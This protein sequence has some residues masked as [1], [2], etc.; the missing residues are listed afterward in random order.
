MRTSKSTITFLTISINPLGLSW[1]NFASVHL[2]KFV[3]ELIITDIFHMAGHTYIIYADRY[4]GW[5]EVAVSKNPNTETIT[6]ILRSYFPTFGVPKK[7]SSDGGPHLTDTISGHF[8]TSGESDIATNRHTTHKASAESAVKS[9]SF[10]F[11]KFIWDFLFFLFFVSVWSFRE[12]LWFFDFLV[13]FLKAVRDLISTL[14]LESWER[15]IWVY[16]EYF[17]QKTLPDMQ[18][19][20]FCNFSR[21]I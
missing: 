2:G 5:T 12:F 20:N 7:L 4:S 17:L 13:I 21:C 10:I 15:C 16:L 19:W 1:W 18:V 6:K 8:L 11:S 9:D 3:L 14:P